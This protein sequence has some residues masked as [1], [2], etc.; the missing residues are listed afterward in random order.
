MQRIQLSHGNEL[1][2][3][4]IENKLVSEEFSE[5]FYKSDS[6]Q[7]DIMGNA[8]EDYNYEL[9]AD[10]LFR[11]MENR[12]CRAAIMA[13]ADRFAQGVVKD[14]AKYCPKLLLEDEYKPFVEFVKAR[15]KV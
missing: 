9:S 5:P 11:G 8:H 10:R 2:V 15:K 13:F 14:M 4:L 3:Y 12:Y 6:E 1:H 7:E